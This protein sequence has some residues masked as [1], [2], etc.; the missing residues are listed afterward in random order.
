VGKCPAVCIERGTHPD[1]LLHPLPFMVNSEGLN[2]EEW[3]NSKCQ[4]VEVGFVSYADHDAKVS[5]KSSTD[6]FVEVH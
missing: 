6:L 4:R 2:I 3:L 1:H 5:P